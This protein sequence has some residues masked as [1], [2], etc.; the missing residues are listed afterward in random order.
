MSISRQ[1]L[2]AVIV[3]F[4]SENVI[5][6]CIRS[7][8]E[9]IKIIIVDNSMD[10]EFKENLEKKYKNVECILS[11]ENLGMGPG[12]NLGLKYVK[13]DYAFVLNPDVILEKN[14]IDE[15]ILSSQKIESFS[16]IAPISNSIEYP[17]YKLDKNHLYNKNNAFEVK[18]VDGYAMLLNLKKMNQLEIFDDNKYF[19]ENFFM[20]LENDDLCKRLIDC[21]ER[22]YV[23]PKSEIKHLGAKAV[24]EKYREEIELS[25]N[26]HWVWSKFYY[27]QKHFGFF[28]ALLNGL[29]SFISAIIK[30][31]FYLLI[32]KRKKSKVYLNRVL[33]FINALLGKRSSYR[34]NLN[35]D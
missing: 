2:T 11:S 28:S 24:D 12:N 21:G 1:N 35:F 17:N 7:I 4:K 33:G 26:W 10:K 13:T 14:S 22:I 15:I 27:N 30:F 5:H 25:R 29:P 8:S 18:S 23:V 20:Y 6:E 9:S 31:L 16:V 32:L 3:T 34:P 19:D